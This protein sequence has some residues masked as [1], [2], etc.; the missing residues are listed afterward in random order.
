MGMKRSSAVVLAAA[1]LAMVAPAARAADPYEIDV[2]LPLTGNLAFV[3]ETQQ[4]AIKAV[5]AYV[6]K[7]GG[8]DGR[9]VSF[10]FHDDQ[11]SPETAL[12][13]ARALIAQNAAVILGPSSPQGCSAIA[14]LVAQ[15]GPVLYCLANSGHPLNGG[16]E[17]LTLFPYT[18]QFAVTY[19]YFH[20]RRWK[21]IAYI[22]ST[23]GGG[24]EAEAA[25]LSTAALP[26]NKDLTFVAKEHFAPGAITVAAQMADIKAANPDAVI[27]WAT[28][29][30]AGTL[31]RAAS[32]AGIDLPAVTSGGNMSANF[33]KQFG[34]VLPTNLYFAAVPY[35]AGSAVN[36]PAT[37]Q[38]IATLTASLAAENAKPDMI[39]ISAWD[40]ALI[41]VDALRKL[42]V[43]ATAAQLHA[44]LDG[45]RNW[46]G[47]NG[48]YDFEKYPQRG[49]GENNVI[50]VRW[51]Q[52]Q[53]KGIAVSKLGGAPP[54]SI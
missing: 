22:V 7:T 3:G 46:N 36:S 40:P 14:P 5:E 18:A 8:I 54:V 11:G 50:M 9:P 1:L 6:N 51:D 53:H 15:N 29:G 38:A 26:A 16:Y 4:T 41:V 48:T 39:E 25:M 23:D 34:S 2:I 27:F 52:Q 35:Y 31:F 44:Y 24:Q 43:N 10:A 19:D 21:R 30:S 49:I 47:V 13:L 17:F 32:N 28:G 42:G 33:F 12:Q 37:N 45:L 20:Q